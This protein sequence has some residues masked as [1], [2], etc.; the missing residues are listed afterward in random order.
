M[1]NA[2]IGGF[3]VKS[4]L[5]IVQLQIGMCP[6]FD[7]LWDELTVEEHLLFYARV[8]GVSPNE[9]EYQVTKALGEV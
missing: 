3:S 2:W 9:E 4:Q 5:E 7:V 8:K 6:Q 1:G